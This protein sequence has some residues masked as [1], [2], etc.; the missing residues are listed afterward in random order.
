MYP[1]FCFVNLTC[2]NTYMTDVVPTNDLIW[3][4][5]EDLTI[6][7]VYNEGPS[8][9]ETPVDLTGYSLRMDVVGN[10]GVIYTF[11]TDDLDQATVDE[12]VLGADGS[13]N[14]DV[15]RSLTL[16]GG[17]IFAEMQSTNNSVFNYDVFLRN[18]QGK[19]YPILRG[20]ITVVKSYTLWL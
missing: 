1:L 3:Q 19:Q 6:S 5:G 13:I 18:P 10:T 17:D 7:L 4:Q 20:T 15:P 9:A 16:S 11:N 8:G 14:I 2:Y 12:A